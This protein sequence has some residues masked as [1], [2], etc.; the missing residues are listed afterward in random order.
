M[1][2]TTPLRQNP[3]SP[4]PA[5]PVRPR[6]VILASINRVEGDTGV[7]THGRMLAAGLRAAGVDCNVVSAFNGSKKWLPVFALRPLLLYRINKTWSTLWHRRFHRAALRENLMRQ[8]VRKA[9]DAILAQCPVSA[10]AALDV[11]NAMNL[12]TPIAMVCHFNHSE[13]GEYRDKG[14][15]AGAKAYEDMLACEQRILESVDRVIYVSN[16]ARENVEKVRGVNARSS[17]VI[18]NGISVGPAP[19]LTRAQLGLG[20]DDVVL[21][22]VGSIEPRKNQLGLID[23]FAAVHAQCP[24]TKLVLVGDGPQRSAVEA[25]IAERRLTDSVLLLGHRRDVAAILPSADVYVH[26]AS[27]ENCPLVLLEAAR[28]GVPVAAIPAGGVPELQAALDCR[29]ELDPS[30]LPGTVNRLR[31]LLDDP[32]LRHSQ[33]AAARAA[34]ERNFTQESMTEAYLNALSFAPL[35]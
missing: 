20:D 26:Y 13:A 3:S 22:N 32:Q 5:R 1:T 28:A 31:P 11:R 35:S 8:M 18:W 27:L 12:A 24:R 30:D 10:A 29:V 25:K 17:A 6:S 16:W 19:R 23:L 2:M 15:L 4:R 21:I 7:H 33:G 34:F 9:P 14:E